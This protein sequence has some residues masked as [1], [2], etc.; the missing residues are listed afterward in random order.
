M[1]AIAAEAYT[2]RFIVHR[3]EERAELVELRVACG[4]D[5]PTATSA[6]PPPSAQLELSLAVDIASIV[7]E[8]PERYAFERRFKVDVARAANVTPRRVVIDGI[9]QGSV[10]VT[11]HITEPTATGRPASRRSADALSSDDAI[12]RLQAALSTGTV[13]VVGE[14]V[15][16]AALVVVDADEELPPPQLSS[17]SSEPGALSAVPERDSAND[18]T[19]GLVMAAVGGAAVALLLGAVVHLCRKKRMKLGPVEDGQAQAAAIALGYVEHQEAGPI[20]LQSN[21]LAVDRSDSQLTFK[22]GSMRP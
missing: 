6:S 7:P 22:N 11:F 21:A 3:R 8:T 16:A 9:R 18:T 5:T 10:V 14:E 19:G 12:A 13:M 15:P 4:A 17:A 1:L 20:G 2:Y